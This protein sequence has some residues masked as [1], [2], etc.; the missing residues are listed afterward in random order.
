MRFLDMPVR[1]RKVDK[2][3]RMI[4]KG[5]WTVRRAAKFAGLSYHEILV[6]MTEEVVD[7]GPTLKE[8]REGF[9]VRGL[10]P[11]SRARPRLRE[12]SAEVL[13]RKMRRGRLEGTS[14]RR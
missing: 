6:K 12:P 1:D 13:V 4:Q 11:R 2:A 10:N 14:R 8:L 9:A 7:S 3:L 5:R